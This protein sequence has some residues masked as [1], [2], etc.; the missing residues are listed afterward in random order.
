MNRLANCL[1]PTDTGK[2]TQKDLK[3]V[4]NTSREARLVTRTIYIATKLANMPEDVYFITKDG[5]DKL[6]RDFGTGDI[7][8]ET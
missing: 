6:T 7:Y 2:S 4:V 1:N 3:L 8:V 5:F